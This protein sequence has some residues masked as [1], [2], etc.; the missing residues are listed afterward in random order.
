ML[1]FHGRG[2]TI[3]VLFQRKKDTDPGE[4][5]KEYEAALGEKVLAKT[6]GRYLSGWDEY[7]EPLWGLLI[8]TSGGFRFHHFPHESWITAL[9]RVTTGGK[10]PS[11]KTIFIPGNRILSASLIM[12]KR[13]WKQFLAPVHPLFKLRYLC[14]G[15][16][17]ELAA[18]TDL[19]AREIIAAIESTTGKSGA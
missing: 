11:E 1:F 7:G 8:A 16:E 6:L 12:E 2:Y 10:P 15:G 17:R 19:G 18:E 9:T 3:R 13:W 5:W 14:P 4:F